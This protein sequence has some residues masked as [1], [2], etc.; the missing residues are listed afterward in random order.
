[1]I[2]SLNILN[3]WFKTVEDV[4]NDIFVFIQVDIETPEHLKENFSEMCPIF[5]NAEIHFDDIEEYMK[6]Y[7]TENKLV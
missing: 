4:L 3:L 1:M 5:E 6:I 7:H 2:D